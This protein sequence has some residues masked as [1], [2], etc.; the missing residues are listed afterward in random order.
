M[1]RK[2]TTE[3]KGPELDIH[4]VILRPVISEK[5]L[6]LAE[7][8]NQYTFEVHP[9][10]TKPQIKEAVERLF[11]VRVEAVRIVKLKG[12]Q[13]RMRFTVGRTAAK[14]KAIVKLHPDYRLNFI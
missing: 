14:K 6:A 11:D 2:Q 8:R 10:A 7:K 5:S 12:K 3:Q 13:R 4:Q 9:W 1:A